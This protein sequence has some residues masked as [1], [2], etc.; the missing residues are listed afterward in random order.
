MTALN[1][2]LKANSSLREQ[3]CALAGAENV[4]PAQPEDAVAGT[5][6]QW[7]VAAGSEQEVASILRFA[8]EVR[9][10]VIPRGGGTK[11]GW[12]NPPKR[13]DVILSLSGLSR[14]VEHAWADLTVSVEAGCTIAELQRIL[15][16]HGQRLAVDPL[17]PERATIGGVLSTNDTGA[18]RLRYGGL[19]DLVIGATLALADGTLAKSGGKVVKNVAGYDLPKLATGALGTLGVITRAIFRVHPVP[20]ATRTL[21]LPFPEVGGMQRAL[22][23]ILN[24]PLS[25][26]SLQVHL[27]YDA[28]PT[29][30][31][32]FEG[33]EAGL[34]SEA[35]RVQQLVRP[36]PI[37]S[38]TAGVWAARQDL[39]AASDTAAIAK[40]SVIPSAIGKAHAA[41]E[42]AT[43]RGTR[44]HA[45]IQA[46]GIGLLRLEAG[47]EDSIAM[48]AELR[49]RI[50]EDGGSCVVLRMPLSKVSS[51]TPIRID[52]WGHTG[53]ALPLMIAVKQQFDPHRTLNPGR[54]V[55][56]I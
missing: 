19:R 14:V 51:S 2:T 23:E 39:W 46:T 31:I 17:W 16:E 50:E 24:S 8:N 12:G 48:L 37:N 20:I 45:V 42:R 52:A 53:D 36:L 54:N 34:S 43:A 35:L 15:A 49:A 13:A 21:R 47:A 41:I 26:A 33:S 7:I 25:P 56:G 6:A 5:P 1:I 3:L 11:L 38:T 40:I 9:V 4:R 22:L 30:D 44:W 55:G 28:L 27:G 32:G 29:I 10:A 18:L